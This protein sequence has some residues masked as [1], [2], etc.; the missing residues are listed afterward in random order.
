MAKIESKRVTV[1]AAPEQIYAFLSDMNNI[2][3]LLP[4]DK[5]SDWKSTE[6][7]CSF[8]VQGAYTIGLQLQEGVPHSQIHYYSAPGGP[9]PFDLVCHLQTAGDQTEGYMVCNAQLNPFLEMMVKSPLKNLFDY[10]ADR[11]TKVH[12]S[13]AT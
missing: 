6:K 8:K 10:M 2:K 4:L 7:E 5:V 3:L 13:P 11:L 1:K 9:F 12:E